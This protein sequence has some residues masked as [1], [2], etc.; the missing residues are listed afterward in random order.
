MKYLLDVN[1]LFALGFLQHELHE[2]VASSVHTL[3]SRGVPEL[4]TSVTEL[5]F[6]RVLAQAPQ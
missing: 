5:D 2:R 3:A 4:A 1:V 6:V